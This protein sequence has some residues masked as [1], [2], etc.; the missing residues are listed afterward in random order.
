M[1][2]RTSPLDG[3]I[4]TKQRAGA[5]SLR[6]CRFQSPVMPCAFEKKLHRRERGERRRGVPQRSARTRR[7]NQEARRE[8]PDTTSACVLSVLS[9]FSVVK[10]FALRSLRP[11]RCTVFP[12]SGNA[13]GLRRHTRARTPVDRPVLMPRLCVAQKPTAGLSTGGWVRRCSSECALGGHPGRTRDV[14]SCRSS[15]PSRRG[16]C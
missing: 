11:P 8:S 10:G 7:G 12:A 15:F 1:N 4:R 14:I 3:A 16:G 13:L 5:S 2:V 6:H 9:V